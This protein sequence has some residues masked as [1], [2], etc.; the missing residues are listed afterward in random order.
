VDVPRD[1]LLTGVN[2]DN[3]LSAEVEHRREIDRLYGL[4]FGC[5]LLGS[6]LVLQHVTESYSPFMD[7]D[8]LEYVLHIPTW[9]RRNYRMYDAWIKTYYPAAAQWHHKFV[10]IGHRP[11]MVMLCGRYMPLRTLPKRIWQWVLKHVLGLDT[12]VLREGESMNPYDSW[13]QDNHRLRANM[14]TYFRTHIAVLNSNPSILKRA[15]ELYRKGAVYD[16]CKVL[17]LLSAIN[18]LVR[19]DE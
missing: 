18:R 16:K 17:T 9:R 8:F 6:P 19:I 10:Q 13:Y 7:V 11:V 12:Y 4:S 5:N 1:V 15:D 14:D 3:I 2:G